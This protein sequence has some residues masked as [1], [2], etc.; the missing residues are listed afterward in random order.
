MNSSCKI[1][2]RLKILGNQSQVIKQP[3]QQ[4]P[5]LGYGFV[6]MPALLDTWLSATKSYRYAEVTLLHNKKYSHTE[7]NRADNHN[8]NSNLSLGSVQS[9][10]VW[11]EK[12][13]GSLLISWHFFSLIITKK[14][15]FSKSSQSFKARS[16]CC[17]DLDLGKSKI[18]FLNLK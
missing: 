7:Q 11:R 18:V 9:M 6:C 14:I 10:S 15:T 17:Q 5:A 2:N 13:A 16:C 12:G 8:I 4:S 3:P 1:Q